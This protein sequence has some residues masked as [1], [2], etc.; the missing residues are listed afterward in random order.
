MA[1]SKILRLKLY[2][3]SYMHIL[4]FSEQYRYY[5]AK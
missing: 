4:G 5:N 2:V 3:L 1:G